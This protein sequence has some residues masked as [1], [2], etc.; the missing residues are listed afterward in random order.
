MG[1]RWA[2][3]GQVGSC[4]GAA[5]GCGAAGRS[6]RINK[7]QGAD[8]RHVSLLLCFSPQNPKPGC[9]RAF[10]RIAR[11]FRPGIPSRT[12]GENGTFLGA[13]LA[14]LAP[15]FHGVSEMFSHIQWHCPQA[16]PRCSLP[17]SIGA[18]KSVPIR[19]SPQPPI[20]AALSRRNSTGSAPLSVEKGGL[21][22]NG[23]RRRV[24]KPRGASGRR[25]WGSCRRTVPFPAQC[26]QRHFP[27]NVF[28]RKPQLWYT[29]SD[30]RCL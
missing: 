5:N 2:L 21:Q 15:H 24:R 14:A 11:A 9:T 22:R 16:R 26:L 13:C 1:C 18:G 4:A 3:T 12:G 30:G 8:L 27:K 7:T 19:R 20:A 6:A 17:P 29:H 10:R 28:Y 25:S 23:I